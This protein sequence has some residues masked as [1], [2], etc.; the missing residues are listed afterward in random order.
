MHEKL[1]RIDA[2]YQQY[3]WGKMGSSSAVAQYAAHSDKNVKIDDTKPYA[4]LW[5]GTHLK[6]PCTTRP[7]NELLNDVIAK[8]PTT[9]LGKDI[10]EKF[11]SKSELPF[12]FKV[13]SIKKVLSIQAHP[14]KKLARILHA[15]DPKNY[16]DDNHK[17][18]MAIAVTDFEGFCG[19]KP[20]EEIAEELSRLP[21]FRKLVGEDVAERFVKGI[22]ANAVEGSKDDVANRKLLQELF[23]KVMSASDE[24]VAEQGAALIERAKRSP[25][26]FTQCD[27]P[28]LLVRLNDQFPG[29]VGLYCG[30]LLL[31]HCRLKA[32]E[33]IFLKAKDPHAYISGDIM[34][35]MAASDNVVRA[36]FTP[37]FKDVENLVEML[38]YNYGT[39]DDQKMKPEGFERS[40]G[41]GES[42]LYDPPIEEFAVLETTFKKSTGVR[43]FEP[44]KGPSILITTKGH[45]QVSTEGTKLQAEPGF[46]FFIAPNTAI[47]LEA[48]DQDFTTYRAFVEA[49]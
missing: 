4:E 34:E 24:A 1:F 17:P 16:P 42:I 48:N 13:L 19:F 43:H 38:T 30:G 8:D 18:E 23:G 27:L 44:L 2:T 29:D 39:V 41:A 49:N 47:D 25:A 9:M 12:L 35:C 3:E 15:Q 20:L 45:G 7:G 6:G 14:D 26:D 11:Q 32:G 22:K 31:N 36:G 46:V 5:M 28:E 21:E 40:S 33:A 37:K 10:I